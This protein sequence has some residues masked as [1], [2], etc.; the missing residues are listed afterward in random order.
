MPESTPTRI[1][2]HTLDTLLDEL[3]SGREVIDSTGD[4]FAAFERDSRS[5]LEWFRKNRSI[6]DGTNRTEFASQITTA[7][8][9]DPPDRPSKVPQS[10]T[11]TLNKYQISKVRISRFGGIHEFGNLNSNPEALEVNL[12]PSQ[13]K[14][15][16]LY[17]RNGCGKS[18]LLSAISWCLTGWFYQPQGFP[19]KSTMVVEYTCN[20]GEDEDEKATATK[21]KALP[22]IPMPPAE[23][24]D[25]VIKSKYPIETWVEVEIQDEIGNVHGP[26]RRTAT[27]QKGKVTES[28]SGN[29]ATLG[30]SPSDLEI[31]TRLPAMLPH[32]RLDEKN[33]LGEA[34]SKL[35]DIQPIKEVARHAEKTIEKIQKK[36]IQDTDDDLSI[37]REHIRKETEAIIQLMDKNNLVELK[38]KYVDILQNTTSENIDQL[39]RDVEARRGVLLSSASELLGSDVNFSNS[40][41]QKQMIK[42]VHLA[43]HQLT[44]E[45]L[46]K[47][48]CIKSW[49]SLAAL[50]V[51]TIQKTE[52]LIAKILSEANAL[53]E[54]HANPDRARRIQLYAKV[55]NWL[56]Q[57][58]NDIP[59]ECPVCGQSLE[60]RQDQQTGESIH[61]H[62]E[63]CFS[64]STEMWDRAP[65]IWANDY[66]GKL[67]QIVPDALRKKAKASPALQLGSSMVKELSDSACFG[68][69]LRPLADNLAK[70]WN[71]VQL[72]IPDIPV[73]QNNTIPQV[74]QADCSDLIDQ[75]D[76]IETNIKY[77]QIIKQ[78]EWNRNKIEDELLGIVTENVTENKSLRQM[79]L[80][81]A[82]VTNEAEPLTKILEHAATINEQLEEQKKLQSQKKEYNRAIKALES[83]GR[84]QK[85]VQKQVDGL[86]SNL[87]SRQKV[88]LDAI[89]TPARL[90]HPEITNP[91][92]TSDGQLGFQAAHLGTYAPA[93]HISNASHLRATLV[94]FY[95]AYWEH[96]LAMRGG[97]RTILFDD[98]QD[99]FDEDNQLQLARAIP[100]IINSEAQVILTTNKKI[101]FHDIDQKQVKGK[102]WEIDWKPGNP[103]VQLLMSRKEIE[104]QFLDYRSDRTDNKAQHLAGSVRVYAETRLLALFRHERPI[105]LP[106]Q[107]TLLDAVNVIARLNNLGTQPFD[108]DAI[109][110]LLKNGGCIQGRPLYLLLNDPHH[111]RADQITIGKVDTLLGELKLL[112]KCVNEVWDHCQN[113]KYL[114]AVQLKLKRTIMPLPQAPSSH[115]LPNDRVQV[116]TSAAASN[117]DS[118]G[119]EADDAGEEFRW[120]QLGRI[121]IY[122]VLSHSLGLAVPKFCRVIVSLE[123]EEI[124][125]HSLVIALFRNKVFARRLARTPG[126]SD[127]VLL[128]SDRLDPRNRA[129]VEVIHQDSLRL[130]PIIGVIWNDCETRTGTGEAILDETYDLNK[131]DIKVAQTVN[132]LSAEPFVLNKQK[133][134]LGSEIH[135]TDIGRHI[136]RPV[137]VE[138]KDKRQF[139]KIVSNSTMGPKDTVRVLNP[140]GGLGEPIIVHGGFPKKQSDDFKHIPQVQRVRPMHVVLYTSAFKEY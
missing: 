30:L 43:E 28:T 103:V 45:E 120:G 121:A 115:A 84:L 41:I 127:A 136:D 124:P 61:L 50:A 67:A 53:A 126:Q 74:L 46:S 91:K 76:T 110:S 35:I 137:S 17:G 83:L 20:V 18:S 6:W 23:V 5:I 106:D 101:F 97:L 12:D 7:M 98:P 88:W 54:L 99:L 19:A 69:I 10:S 31:G 118:F 14:A 25:L 48:N 123:E 16:L 130:F 37:S 4:V 112:V 122:Q 133:I 128:N 113:S 32:I 66:L 42:D 27:I 68:E 9:V 29:F 75:L 87:K 107:P 139:L 131:L 108:G 15:T 77:A 119:I 100:K 49:N 60:S 105:S 36:L 13:Y 78:S 56:K 40:D 57:E 138:L 109:T 55:A 89:Y 52:E 135:W 82:E 86:L 70:R 73:T 63:E 39:K 85:L 38:N 71:E 134:L 22:I 117:A 24:L 116:L 114:T 125:D 93:H 26:F 47:L 64:E 140:L 65:D 8:T 21:L 129:P 111:S 58:S 79:I 132:G 33:G 94:A 11:K 62:L 92:L 72:N 3:I 96:Q 34:V 80:T 1:E 59:T 81:L 104:Q 102:R 51:E 90:T 44:S 2:D 95:L